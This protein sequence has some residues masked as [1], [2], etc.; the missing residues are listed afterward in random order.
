MWSWE[1]EEFPAWMAASQELVDEVW[2]PSAH[3]SRAIRVA[4]DKPVH[5]FPNPVV[6]R[7]SSGRGRADLGLPD[8]FLFLFSFDAYSGAERKNPGAAIEAFCRAFAPGEG[9]QLVVKSIN[10]HTNLPALERLRLLAGD[11]PDV[12]VVDGYL[13]PTDQRALLECCDAY[14]SLHRAEG[15]GY[16]LA[17]AMLAGKPAIGTAY[18]GNLEFMDETNSF[19]VE[20]AMTPIPPGCDPYPSTSR[21]AE[22]DVEHA[23]ELMRRV[24]EDPTGAAVVAER[25]RRTIVERHSPAAR[26]PL[27]AARLAAARAEAAAGAEAAVLTPP[28][29][30]WRSRFGGRGVDQAAALLRLL[31]R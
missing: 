25:G 1:V 12:R 15:F 3:A 11:R 29:P 23:A 8:G 13:D 18:S 4:I 16:T 24:V 10:G 7:P 9:P 14:V 17:E 31:R 2:T 27:L 26:V 6:D 21:W 30:R 28:L 19:L 22:P 20:Y 5:T